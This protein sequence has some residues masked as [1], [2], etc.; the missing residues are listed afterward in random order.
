MTSGREIDPIGKTVKDIVPANP[1]G[2]FLPGFIEALRQP[3][4]KWRTYPIGG[5]E[6]S[7][8]DAAIS[9]GMAVLKHLD[10]RF[11]IEHPAQPS[12]EAIVGSAEIRSTPENV[13]LGLDFLA[14]RKNL[15]LSWME[16]G[17]GDKEK[18]NSFMGQKGYSRLKDWIERLWEIRSHGFGFNWGRENF[19]TE[20]SVGLSQMTRLA[21]TENGLEGQLTPEAL[22]AQEREVSFQE[23]LRHGLILKTSR[24]TLDSL[25]QFSLPVERLAQ[26]LEVNASI[27]QA[28][29]RICLTTGYHEFS[30]RHNQ[31]G[32]IYAE[33]SISSPDTDRR[34]SVTRQMKIS[35]ILHDTGKIEVA[36]KWLADVNYIENGG[37][38][39]PTTFYFKPVSQDE[40]QG[41]FRQIVEFF[42]TL[43]NRGLK[44]ENETGFAQ[45]PAIFSFAG[46]TPDELATVVKTLP[47]TTT[48]EV[49]GYA[50]G[51]YFVWKVENGQ[52]VLVKE[53]NDRE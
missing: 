6:M 32:Y 33:P 18:V 2:D 44:F 29:Y 10:D 27:D 9:I 34:E 20:F 41:S 12:G 51:W 53:A 15:L 38:L 14:Q 7:L 45:T 52:V 26:V 43:E 23:A 21:L 1:D 31:Q 42:Q 35:K 13:E 30:P 28:K 40:I 39:L 46:V 50:S 4:L 11:K 48:A 36:E 3:G 49:S 22:L 37:D 17:F 25:L 5:A 19:L 24:M 16:W 8:P 47:S